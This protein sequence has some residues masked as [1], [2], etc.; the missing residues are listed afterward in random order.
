MFA[1]IAF[2]PIISRSELKVFTDSQS[3][4]RI[5]EVGSMNLELQKLAINIFSTCLSNNIRLEIEWI[6]RNENEQADYVSRLI[7]DWCISEI[8]VQMISDMWGPCNKRNIA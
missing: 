4:A 8:F 3:A 1:L 5:I 6:P 2:L 7:D